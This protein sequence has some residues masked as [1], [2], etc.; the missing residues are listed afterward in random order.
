[1]ARECNS[2]AAEAVDVCQNGLNEDNKVVNFVMMDYPN[3]PGP[4]GKTIVEIADRVNTQRAKKLLQ[5]ERN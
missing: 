1:M 4:G 3:Y 2:R 5:V